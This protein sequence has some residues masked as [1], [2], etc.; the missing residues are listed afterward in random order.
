MKH[1]ALVIGAGRIGAGFAWHDLEYTH[2]G[3]YRALPDRVELVGFVE[4]DLDRRVKANLQWK[5]PTFDN[6]AAGLLAV[7]PDVV[8]ICT[9][10]K[11]QAKVIK[12]CLK[13]GVKG[14]YCEKPYQGPM[15]II[16][17][18]IQ[19]NYI[20]R[21]C[22]VHRMMKE[23]LEKDKPKATLFVVAKDDIHTKCHFEDLAKWW[24]CDLEYHVYNGPNSY[25]LRRV[26][27]NGATYETLFSMG[28]TDGGRCMKA[29][30]ENLLDHMDNGVPLWSP[31]R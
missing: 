14:I 21:G 13:A 18:P 12:A 1:R 26:Y 23:H 16:G 3:A 25:F 22:N 31:E 7:S 30:A 29:M 10:P 9:Q 8:S 19:V 27:A 24:G 2:A 15:D 5:V 11:D 17:V 28:G 4:P 20:R 6:V